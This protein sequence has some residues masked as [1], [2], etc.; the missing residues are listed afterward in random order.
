MPK[1][2]FGSI[3]RRT[4]RLPDGTVMTLPTWWIKYA[5]NGQVFRESSGSEKY[6]DAE[7][8]LKLRVGEIAACRFQGLTPEKT[9]IDELL[10]DVLLDYRVN[11]KALRFAAS[12]INNHL[13]PYFSGRRAVT[14]GTSDVQ[15]YVA[16][17]RS[18]NQGTRPYRGRKEETRQI[19]I[20][21]GSN[22]TIN[23][24]LS[25]LK[26]AFYLGMK[27]TPRKVA[28]VPYIP[29]LEE[30]N[31]R[32]GFFEH[33]QFLMVRRALPG[34]VQSVVTFAYYTGCRRGEILDLRWEQVDLAERIVRLEPGTTKND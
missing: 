26:H 5:R 23:R 32:K 11:D 33:D 18:S 19:P 3:Y 21:P 14:I 10:D 6:A 31:V 13:R 1:P 8:L 4:K 22:A 16:F 24:E 15:K 9:V 34:Y 28:S 20:L 7:R 25:L 12:A 27:H 2:R 17:R 29:L 30:N